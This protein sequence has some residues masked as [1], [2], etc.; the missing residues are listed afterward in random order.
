[1]PFSLDCLVD[2]RDLLSFPTRRSSDLRLTTE[3]YKADGV[4]FAVTLV[5]LLI[6]VLLAEGMLVFLALLVVF[7]RAGGRGLLAQLRTPWATPLAAAIGACLLLIVCGIAVN[8]Y[9]RPP[10]NQYVVLPVPYAI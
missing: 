10:W 4:S 7:A 2:H 3:R 1:M 6:Q 8:A 5:N 9:M